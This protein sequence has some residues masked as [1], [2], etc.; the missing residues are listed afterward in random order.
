[1]ANLDFGHL[2][3]GILSRNSFFALLVGDYSRLKQESSF[4]NEGRGIV[5]LFFSVVFACSSGIYSTSDT[6]SFLGDDGELMIPFGRFRS[7]FD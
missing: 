6:S 4:F 1:M 5:S 3:V 7:P 2:L